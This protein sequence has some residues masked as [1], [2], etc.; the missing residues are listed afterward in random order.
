MSGQSGSSTTHESCGTGATQKAGGV[1]GQWSGY[2]R[3]EDGKL[4]RG[5]HAPDST[6]GGGG[7]GGYYGGGAGSWSGGGGGSSYAG[8]LATNVKHE[9]G[10]NSENGKVIIK[11]GCQMVA[12]EVE[13][14]QTMCF[15]QEITL[16]AKVSKPG[17]KY[18]WDN[19]VINGEPFKPPM[20]VTKYTVT[21]SDPKECPNSIEIKVNE[22]GNLK[23]TTTDGIICDGEFTTLIAHGASGEVS[24]SNGV[25]DGVPFRPPVGV[26]T[27]KL[28][29]E[30]ACG[31]E[32]EIRIVVNKI[33]IKGDM[34]EETPEH[35]GGVEV[36]VSGGSDPYKYKWTNA[37][38]QTVS[39]SRDLE[40]VKGGNYQ[41]EVTD[42]I[43]C[44]DKITYTVNTI[45]EFIEEEGPKLEAEM[46]VDQKFIT[47][48]YPGPFEY[49]IENMNNEIM[50]TGHSVD[51][52]EVDITKLPPGQYRVSLIYKQIKQYVTFFK[53]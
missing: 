17:I 29:K 50:I 10:V 7:G 39:L 2:L 38:G 43:G 37:A 19:G 34:M 42:G 48:S 24:W 36:E 5:G 45:G 40:G 3:G 51:S 49:E 46:S 8:P 4:G 41:L 25:K 21:S 44:T 30:G 35:L 1:G 18:T 52:D 13:G 20:G 6:A 28:T 31:G 33:K 53:D 16:K 15:G 14:P 11:A 27:Y 32:D 22:G 12:I 47:V 23:A 9:Q 26:T